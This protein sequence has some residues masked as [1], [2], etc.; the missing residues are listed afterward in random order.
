MKKSKSSTNKNKNKKK[1]I[2]TNKKVKDDQ[3]CQ[4]LCYP[5]VYTMKLV[6]LA[7][8]CRLRSISD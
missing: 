5:P 4:T 6:S 8:V 3:V 7:I 2:T 1:S